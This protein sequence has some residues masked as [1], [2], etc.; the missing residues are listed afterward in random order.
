MPGSN[1]LPLAGP[2]AKFLRRAAF[3]NH[4]LW[5]TSYNRDECFPGG[6]FPNQNPR[7]GE[8]IP[9]WVQQDRKLEETDI[10][11]WYSFL[12]PLFSFHFAALMLQLIL[13]FSSNV[14]SFSLV[15]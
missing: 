4:N 5:V 3:L 10:V 13:R 15:M 7:V 1:C 14:T 9:T 8:G 11:L 6:E 2:D 12:D